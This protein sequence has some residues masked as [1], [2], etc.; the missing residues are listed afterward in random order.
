MEAFISRFALKIEFTGIDLLKCSYIEQNHKYLLLEARHPHRRW[1]IH[2]VDTQYGT[3][4]GVVRCLR[5][6]LPPPLHLGR[7][8]SRN[9]FTPFNIRG[10]HAGLACTRFHIQ[11]KPLT[12][13][14]LSLYPHTLDA[15]HVLSPLPRLLSR[16][17]NRQLRSLLSNEKDTRC[18]RDTSVQRENVVS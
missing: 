8:Q 13:Q 17:Q 16:T 1:S 12:V 5:P 2:Q 15:G 9:I 18:W 6:S 7:A 10:R 3:I 4:N 14:G 11:N